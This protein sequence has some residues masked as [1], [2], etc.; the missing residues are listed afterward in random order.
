MSSTMKKLPINEEVIQIVEAAIE[1]FFDT[2]AIGADIAADVK[3]AIQLQAGA[4]LADYSVLGYHVLGRW[5][6]DTDH[7]DYTGL[8]QI[9]NRACHKYYPYMKVLAD[10]FTAIAGRESYSET[11]SNTGSGSTSLAKNDTKTK[12]EMGSNSGNS[13]TRYASEDSPVT[14]QSITSAPSASSTWNL[15]NP[16]EKGGQQSDNSTTTSI[17]TTET[18]AATE[19][20]QES[21]TESGSRTHYTDSPERLLA[22]LRFNV[23]DLNAT[24]IA[25]RIINS[26]TEDIN[27]I[28]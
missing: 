14:S 19:S 26:I 12:A 7:F 15:T 13:T 17:N 23:D 22:V 10:E 20:G 5:P 6:Y 24:K 11:F 25:Y 3:A 4:I 28:Y 8:T 1:D 27:T 16:T 21:K 18:D 2:G 9:V